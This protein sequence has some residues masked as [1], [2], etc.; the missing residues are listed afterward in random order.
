[1]K[2]TYLECGR[3]CNAHGVRGLVKVEHWCDSPRVLAERRR[4][5]IAKGDDFEEH[6]VISASVAGQ[7]VLMCIEGI[8]S[9]EDAVAM[10]G[11]VLYLHRDDIPLP[12]GS[13][14]VADM[15]GL[16]V[17]DA[18]TGKLYGEISEVSDAARGKLFHVKTPS[19]G[20]VLLPDV[21]QFIKRINAEEGMLITPIPGFFD[22]I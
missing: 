9:R 20:E 4:V 13:M 7:T 14:L 18:E 12:K 3:V 11:T 5:F 2:K 8:D 15:I 19:G 10:K 17:Y 16:S 21:P 1:M 22:E 6:A